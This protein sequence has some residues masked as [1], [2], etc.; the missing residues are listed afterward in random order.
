MLSKYITTQTST[1]MSKQLLAVKAFKQN[2]GCAM[3]IAFFGWKRSF[4]L[5]C[6]VITLYA[7]N[8]EKPCKK[9][10]MAIK[11]VRSL[12]VDS[13]V[14]G[15]LLVTQ[16]HHFRIAACL[17]AASPRSEIA[18]FI[19]SCRE[20]T[21]AVTAES[22]CCHNVERFLGVHMRA[23]IFQTHLVSFLSPF[24][25]SYW[26]PF[27]RVLLGKL[28]WKAENSIWHVVSKASV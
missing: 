27:L 4:I 11:N 1:G 20:N 19:N 5:L 17:T 25:F 2:T 13:E 15:L 12:C 3:K 10:L 21:T 24:F 26:R 9:E 23:W 18:S 22:P 14:A 7:R 6:K 16:S 8:K 28:S